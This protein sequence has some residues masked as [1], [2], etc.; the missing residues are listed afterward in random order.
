MHVH[1]RE[2][3]QEHKETIETGARA[4]A[5]GGFTA[6][7]CM[8]NTEPPIA[9]RDVVEFVLARQRPLA[10]AV[11]PIGT[12][13]KGREGHEMAE[14]GD[15]Q[16]GGAVAF[17]DDGSPVQHGGLMRRAL[18]YAR[19]LG[20]PILGHEEDL[21]LNADHGHMNE[22]EVATRLGLPGIPGLAEEAMIARDALL[23]EFTGG[24]VHV[25]HISTAR[26]VDIVRRAK[27][28]GV[29]ITAEAC[30][31]HWALTDEAVDASGYDTHTKMHPPL[32]TPADVQAIKDGLADGTIDVIAT[33]HA[34]TRRSR[35]R[36]STSPPRSASW[37]SKRAGGLP[38][39]IWCAPAS[40][41]ST[42]PCK[43]SPSP[44]ARSSACTFRASPLA[45]RPRS[46]S[47]TPTA[48]G[49]SRLAT[50]SRSPRT[51]RS[52]VR[53]CW[54][55]RGASSIVGSGCPR[56]PDP[57][58]ASGVVTRLLVR[59]GAV[60]IAC[61]GSAVALWVLVGLW[62]TPPGASGLDARLIASL[63]H[64]NAEVASG[65][66]ERMQT[67]FPEGFVFTHALRGLAWAEVAA[68]SDEDT[69][70]GRHA[71]AAARSALRAL[72]SPAG[73]APFPEPLDPPH[74]AFWT[75]WTLWLEA[76]ILE[77]TPEARRD[78]GAVASFRARAETLAAALERS[79]LSSGTPY[80]QSYP[81]SA[82]PA[83]ALAGL[84]ALSVHDRTFA[85]R[86][87][88]LRQDWIDAAAAR[89]DSTVGL[90]SHAADPASG[91]PRGGYRGSSQALMLRA[92]AEVDP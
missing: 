17:S 87:E 12:V 16:A 53:R 36:S 48:S 65:E 90:L 47:S 3:G 75:G 69:D 54:A 82:W 4:A 39:A 8:P 45:R 37:G 40:S 10:V 7:A 81:G 15:M 63:R 55:G 18:E 85:P 26:A 52:S 27:A 13:S 78:S 41:R 50:S 49:P 51:L 30:P 9:T 44:R 59:I 86:Y 73:R 20:A 92:M 61:I 58:E 21:T 2:P 66:A 68:Q 11:H 25:C 76:A 23:A 77:A 42:T 64:L 32:R 62:R 74:G 70:L 1:F 31:H 88:A 46:Q 33:D 24:H 43:S 83:D 14:M 56:R 60:L 38:A 89:V 80:L 67:L 5:W 72:E 71:E 22:G 34:H 91:V 79:L 19:T 84:A 35:R 6:V 57:P 28:R 29:P